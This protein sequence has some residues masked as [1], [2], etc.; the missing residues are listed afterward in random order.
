M[1]TVETIGK[2][3]LKHKQGKSIR[4]ISREL[5]LSRNTVR[6]VLRGEETEFT[7][8]RSNQPYPKLGAFSKDLEVFLEADSSLPKKRRRTDTFLSIFTAHIKTP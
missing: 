1:L 5:R 8:Q 2:I 7:Y 3:R 6:K 4:G